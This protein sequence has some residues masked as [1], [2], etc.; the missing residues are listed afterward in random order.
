MAERMVDCN[1]DI[2]KNC[3]VRANSF[4]KTARI[5]QIA[6]NTSV[7]YN[8]LPSFIFFKLPK[9]LTMAKHSFSKLSAVCNSHFN[10]KDSSLQ[11]T[12]LYLGDFFASADPL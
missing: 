9:P 1:D 6:M 5:C 7:L 8:P 10:K 12:A 11:H 3:F 2:C 4:D